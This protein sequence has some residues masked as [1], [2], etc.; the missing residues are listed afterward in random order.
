M[1]ALIA[2]A[3]LAADAASPLKVAVL[4]LRAT[5]VD[6]ALAESLFELLATRV[7][8]AGDFAVVSRS[9]IASMLGFEK[10]KALLACADDSAC[11][12]E[13]SGAL[14]VDRLVTGSV[15]KVGDTFILT[16]K[17]IDAHRARVMGRVS[18]TVEGKPDALIAALVRAVPRIFAEDLRASSARASPP[19]TPARVA[20]PPLAAAER[21]PEPERGAGPFGVVGI[22]GIGALAAG[23]LAAAAGAYFGASALGAIEESLRTTDR[24]KWS[25][26]VGR[27]EGD[28]AIA[29]G[30]FVFAGV[31]GAAGAVLLVL[32]F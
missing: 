23:A 3:L 17:C 22:G 4:E 15:G 12:V 6:P 21:A 9:D 30:A 32:H 16:L 20:S 26:A 14:G 27:A 24:A 5:G 2:L 13:I 1:A 11:L 31:A 18:E 10:Q 19:Q 8:E 29:T 25:A 28:A 7:G